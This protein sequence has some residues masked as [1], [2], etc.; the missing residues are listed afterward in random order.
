[1]PLL[2]G[3]TYWYAAA[4]A[5]EGQRTRDVSAALARYDHERRA[6]T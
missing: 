1:M 5:G 3:R 4:N 2:D 6:R